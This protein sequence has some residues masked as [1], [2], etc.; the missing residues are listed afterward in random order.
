M[1]GRCTQ[2]EAQRF[3]RHPQNVKILGA[4][5]IN[6]LEWLSWWHRHLP[7]IRIPWSLSLKVEVEVEVLVSCLHSAASFHHC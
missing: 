1:E 3:R 6:L 5:R 2:V 7:F 4:P